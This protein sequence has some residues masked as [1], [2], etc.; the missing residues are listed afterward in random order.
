[1][2]PLPPVPGVLS[3]EY[4]FE[5][6]EDSNALVRT[7]YAYSGP[8]PT[9]TDLLAIVVGVRGTIAAYFVNAM[10]GDTRFTEIVCRD[11][12]GPLGA[13]VAAGGTDVGSRAGGPLGAGT[14]VL[15]NYKIGRHYRGGKPR[16]YFP[17][18]A[19]TDLDDRQTWTSGFLSFMG[20][21]ISDVQA[22]WFGATSGGTTV[23]LQ[24][25]VSYYSGFTPVTNVITGR[26]RDVARVRTGP[27]LVDTIT[28]Q[29]INPFIASQRRRDLQR[30]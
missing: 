30:R 14:A 2:A 19:D 4:H 1:M 11:L 6:S 17:F 9:A 26:T 15:V 23:G 7:Y 29:S 10:D 22:A 3:V 25:A 24:V 8:V 28:G 5:I 21:T 18:G 13:A 20:T 27:I 12:S 16:S